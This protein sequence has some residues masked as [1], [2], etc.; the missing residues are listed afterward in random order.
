MADF[1]GDI[2]ATPTNFHG[3]E[4]DESCVGDIRVTAAA[5]AIVVSFGSGSDGIKLLG[6]NGVATVGGTTP[7]PTS[8][9]PLNSGIQE[10]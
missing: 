4:A 9:K 2:R 8:I 3:V 6:G 7:W 1:S 10:P 5:L